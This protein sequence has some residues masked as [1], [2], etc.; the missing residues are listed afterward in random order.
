MEGNEKKKEPKKK[1]E[2]KREERKKGRKEKTNIEKDRVP[3]PKKKKT[4]KVAGP[5]QMALRTEVVKCSSS[6][7][8]TNDAGQIDYQT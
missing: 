8:L 3:G 6:I 5:C 2:E 4:R 1:I 7:M